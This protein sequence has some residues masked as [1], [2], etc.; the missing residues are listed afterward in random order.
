VSKT[1]SNWLDVWQSRAA[2]AERAPESLGSLL[3]SVGFAENGLTPETWTAHIGEVLRRLGARPDD[4]IYEVGCGIGAFLYPVVHTFKH[5]VGG[6][7]YASALVAVAQ[8]AVPGM[9]LTV[10]EASQLPLDESYDLVLSNSVFQY[11]PDL[12]YA[13]AVLER[14]VKKARRAVAV[15]DVNDLA[16]RDEIE[17]RRRAALPPGTYQER[18]RGLEHQYY[19]RGWF[20]DIAGAAGMQVEL[21]EQEIPGF[22]YE[23]LRFNVIIRRPAQA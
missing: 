4:T 5:R 10:G 22:R 3:R 12:A 23:G 15:L 16:R 18:Y 11:F 13:K 8:R 7:D 21:F 1:S 17:A 14:M 9:S 20:E 6:I 19:A 2:E